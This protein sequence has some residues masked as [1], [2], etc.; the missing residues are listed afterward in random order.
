MTADDPSENYT[1]R[2]EVL[3]YL[4]RP[5]LTAIWVPQRIAN[6]IGV[7]RGDQFT[8][9]QFNSATV[10]DLIETRDRANRPAKKTTR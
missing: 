10:Q 7:K 2:R 3:V 4:L 5:D 1:D 8:L 9:E 6:G